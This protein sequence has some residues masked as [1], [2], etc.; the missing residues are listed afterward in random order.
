M[1]KILVAGGFDEDDTRK[2]EIEAF[3]K[4]LGAAIISQGHT[5]LN[6]C[7]TPFDRL[8]A[9]AAYQRLLETKDPNPD[10]RVISYLLA[11]QNQ[12]TTSA[13]LSVR[14]SQTGRLIDRPSTCLSRSNWPTP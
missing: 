12:V 1:L 13:R 14:G 7:Q 3:A 8:V 10:R 5:Y 11:N 6:G 9:E 4:A 2:V